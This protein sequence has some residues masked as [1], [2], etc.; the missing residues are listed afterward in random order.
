MAKTMREPRASKNKWHETDC[1]RPRWHRVATQLKFPI[2]RIKKN[3]HDY[4]LETRY[5]FSLFRRRWIISFPGDYALLPLT[6]SL[7]LFRAPLIA[8]SRPKFKVGHCREPRFANSQARGLNQCLTRSTKTLSVK[9][10]Y[11]QSP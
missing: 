11:V 5:H 2:A 9:F 1:E 6:L 4:H 10:N 3:S 7:S 8:A